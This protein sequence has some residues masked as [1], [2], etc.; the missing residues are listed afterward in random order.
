MT[1]R[2]YLMVIA[3]CLIVGCNGA[4]ATP[5]PY[6]PDKEQNDVPANS[7]K[8]SSITNIRADL[9][10]QPHEII[11]GGQL[12]YLGS[13]TT[14]SFTASYAI[15]TTDGLIIIDPGLSFDWLK[16][17]LHSLNLDLSQVKMALITHR[18]ADHWFAARE[19]ADTTGARIL[20]HPA[21]IPLL[22]H[23]ADVRQY[24]S[25]HRIIRSQVP[26]LDHVEA[27]SDGDVI[28]LG[29]TEI[30]VLSTPG[31]TTGSLCFLT[32]IRGYKVL[33]AGDTIL[34]LGADAGG[35]DYTTRVGPKFG[36]DSVAYVA[37][38]KRLSQLDFDLLLPGHP[39]LGQN[40]DAMV[41]AAQWKKTI[42]QRIAL[43]EERL[44]TDGSRISQFL[45][46]A[47]KEL[48]KDIFYLGECQ[49]TAC[50]VIRDAN[51][52]VC[53][54]PGHRS[55][56]VLD[57][58]FQSLG[59]NTRNTRLV[60]LTGVD[61]S[62]SAAARELCDVSKAELYCGRLDPT[63]SVAQQLKPDRMLAPMTDFEFGKLR[64]KSLGASPAAGADLCFLIATPEYR[65][66]MGGDSVGRFPKDPRS[67][68]P[69]V[70]PTTLINEPQN[71]RSAIE[72]VLNNTLEF[73][74]PAH[75]QYDESP[76]YSPGEFRA[77]IR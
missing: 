23:A 69:D 11:P 15:G 42:P 57:A 37:T 43:L 56:E 30:Q 63:G 45:D 76:Y 49:D 36:G 40:T 47:A 75:P 55:M 31:H 68:H 35:G 39:G 58:Q 18:H 12:Y 1:V 25:I 32:T 6:D 46:G 72:L 54:D 61:P 52:L 62:H 73:V 16:V 34:T 59:L 24:Y 64:L 44:R 70:D 27:V 60:L 53:I 13:D 41:G 19:L 5:H 29:D 65:V 17:A 33:F 67:F 38:L 2:R 4:S 10:E 74:L 77:R 50:Y 14:D 71:V 22:T 20:A 21:E 3:V 9:S 26:V 8:E 66:L 28:K 48:A 51:G 7:G